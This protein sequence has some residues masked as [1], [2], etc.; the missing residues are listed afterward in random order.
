MF[1]ARS[2]AGKFAEPGPGTAMPRRALAVPCAQVRTSQESR[3]GKLLSGTASKAE[4]SCLWSLASGPPLKNTWAVLIALKNI[5]LLSCG[6]AKKLCQGFIT[7]ALRASLH[8]S[9]GGL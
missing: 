6:F 4:L 1:R 8:V 5:V 9:I 7:L 3:A 2:A